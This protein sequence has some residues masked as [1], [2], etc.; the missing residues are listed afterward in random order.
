MLEEVLWLAM[1]SEGGISYTEAYNMP[2]SYR[3]FNIRRISEI[4]K[5]NNEAM[6]KANGKG[7]SMSMEDLARPK[8]ESPDIVTKRAAKK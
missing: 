8:L 6:A 7:N 3:I 5:E 1:N 4:N 2:I